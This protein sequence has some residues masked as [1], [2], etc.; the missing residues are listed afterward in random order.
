[1][2]KT[3]RP[4]MQTANGGKFHLIN[5]E[6]AAVDIK[7]IAEALAKMS[8]F[9]GHTQNFFYSV[10]Q[11]NCLVMDLLPVSAKPYGLLHDAYAAYTGELIIPVQ[12]MLHN[13][14]GYDIWSEVT[15]P[16]QRAVHEAL[17][18][19]YPPHSALQKMVYDADKILLATERRDVLA[20]GPGWEIPMPAPDK[21]V[22]RPWT[23][24]ESH[25]NFME[26]FRTL[27]KMRPEMA[28][29]LKSFG[30]EV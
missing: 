5:P 10:A 9:G 21:H 15:A 17:G 27:T 2:K 28:M 18:L 16:I 6:P 30:H 12:S 14:A 25:H 24:V 26:R 29:A 23:W 13:R 19:Q 7:D 4:W 11:H 1:M 20:D 3:T 8:R 22:I